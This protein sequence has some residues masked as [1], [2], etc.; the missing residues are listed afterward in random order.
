MSKRTKITREN[1]SLI[2]FRIT[3]MINENN[4]FESVWHYNTSKRENNILKRF[5]IDSGSLKETEHSRKS[6]YYKHSTSVER[7]IDFYGINSCFL[8]ISNKN[9]FTNGSQVFIIRIGDA[10]KF[11]K[12]SIDITVKHPTGVSNAVIKLTFKN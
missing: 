2:E 6:I 3:K 8:R 7:E 1:L 5:G 10:V 11:H 9:T 4:R 12:N